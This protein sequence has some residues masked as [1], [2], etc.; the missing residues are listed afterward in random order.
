MRRKKTFPIFFAIIIFI[1]I[2]YGAV[3]MSKSISLR[4]QKLAEISENQKTIDSLKRE[5]E[6]LEEE[7]DDS[8]SLE[9][10]EKVAREQGMVKPR[11]IIYV[12]KDK[13]AED[14]RETDDV[15]ESN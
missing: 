14:A 4:S 8:D 2:T 9:F 13:S 10:L 1:T 12:D 5:I 11:E 15:L 7:I 3:V 6:D